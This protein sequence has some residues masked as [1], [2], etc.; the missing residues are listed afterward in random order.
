MNEQPF[1]PNFSRSHTGFSYPA[2]FPVDQINLLAYI[3]LLK[4]NESLTGPEIAE[5]IRQYS[6]HP[7][8]QLEANNLERWSELVTLAA[9]HVQHFDALPGEFE[10][11]GAVYDFDECLGILGDDAIQLLATMRPSDAA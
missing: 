5:R 2:T 8:C 4:P 1:I 10:F 9:D 3:F 6:A 11:K 7:R